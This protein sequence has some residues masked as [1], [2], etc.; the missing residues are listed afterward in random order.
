MPNYSKIFLKSWKKEESIL[1]FKTHIMKT[2]ERNIKIGMLDKNSSNPVRNAVWFKGNDG[3]IFLG[4]SDF[5]V[6]G[7][8]FAEKETVET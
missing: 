6:E 7:H 8:G 3:M 4:D 5:Y 1:R 2:K